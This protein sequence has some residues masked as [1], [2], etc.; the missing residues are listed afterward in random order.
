M[1][2]SIATALILAVAW[3]L[4]VAGCGGKNAG[5]SASSP[6][7][8]GAGGSPAAPESAAGGGATAAVSPYDG[9]PRASESA[10]DA[11]L[12]AQGEKLFLSK[13]CTVCHGFGKK[14]QCPDLAPVAGQ[15][16]AA[17]MEQQILHP[18]VMTKT[19]PIAKALM[20]QYKLQ[21]TNLNVKPEEAKALIEYIKKKYV[22]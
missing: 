9:G 11:A 6:P 4:L 20:A 7:A 3:S 10:V 1:R 16:T 8:A 15:R 13:G 5:E 12:A 17:W 18:D 2:R 14:V 21:M 22:K 19:D